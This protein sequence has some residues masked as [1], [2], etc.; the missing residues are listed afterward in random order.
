MINKN[1]I[2]FIIKLKKVYLLIYFFYL[3]LIKKNFIFYIFIQI[4]RFKMNSLI[5]PLMF[6]FFAI[7]SAGIKDNKHFVDQIYY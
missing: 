5:N 4:L 2:I 1:F 3:K 7:S 6:L